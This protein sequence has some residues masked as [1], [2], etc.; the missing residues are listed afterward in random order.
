MFAAFEARRAHDR[1]D[2]VHFDLEGT[3]RGVFP[4][5]FQSRSR[6]ETRFRVVVP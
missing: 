1:Q 3:S 2:L 5:P 6:L 4:R